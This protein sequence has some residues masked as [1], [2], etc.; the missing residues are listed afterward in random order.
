MVVRSPVFVV[1]HSPVFVVP[2]SSMCG[3]S[4]G[5]RPSAR[6]YERV[7]PWGAS[8]GDA[9]EPLTLAHLACR[10][11]PRSA[12]PPRCELPSP[13]AAPPHRSHGPPVS[14]LRDPPRWPQH[15]GAPRAAAV[16]ELDV[17][18]GGLAACAGCLAGTATPVATG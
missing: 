8:V 1:P 9:N 12:G 13:L 18:G 6:G 7:W 14:P 10:P 15:L 3:V 4:P 17:V 5:A 11:R 2:R 16:T